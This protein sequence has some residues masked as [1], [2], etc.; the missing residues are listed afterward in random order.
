MELRSVFA[1][2]IFFKNE[3]IHLAPVQRCSANA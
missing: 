2:L 3:G 1:Q